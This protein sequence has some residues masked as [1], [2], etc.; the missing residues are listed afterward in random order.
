MIRVKSSID[1]GNIVFKEG[2]EVFHN[3]LSDTGED[4]WKLGKIVKVDNRLMGYFD[5]VWR[6]DQYG[7]GVEKHN[8]MPLNKGMYK[9]VREEEFCM[10]SKEDQDND[11]YYET[12]CGGAFQ[13]MN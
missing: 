8:W 1:L 10:W 4:N 3:W 5:D 6:K 13:C 11:S 9:V 12:S 7:V 2:D